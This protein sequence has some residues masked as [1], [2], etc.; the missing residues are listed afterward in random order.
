MNISEFRNKV[1]SSTNVLLVLPYLV[2]PDSI[3]TASLLYRFLV[4]KGKKVDVAA[5]KV[6]V[7]IFNNI[8]SLAGI[9]VNKILHEISP[10]RYVISVSNVSDKTS[11]DWER[12][13][14]QL[15]IKLTPDIG[16]VDFESINYSREGGIYDLVITVNVDRLS[17]LGEVYTSISK[18]FE[19]YE[20][21]SVGGNLDVEGRVIVS[22]FQGQ[23]MSTELL[24][25]YANDLDLEIDQVNA[26]II[27]HGIIGQTHGLQKVYSNNTFAIVTDIANKYQLDLSTII[28]QYFASVGI[29]N[30]RVQEKILNNLK[31]D[32]SRKTVYSYLTNR[33]LAQLGISFSNFDYNY[34][35]PFSVDGRDYYSFI[36][37]ESGLSSFVYLVSPFESE[38]YI[39]IV[40]RS[41]AIK[42]KTLAYIS[43]DAGAIDAANQVLGVISG[44]TLLQRQ[45]EE[46]K[47]FSNASSITQHID[48]VSE[49]W[50]YNDNTNQQPISA[51]TIPLNSPNSVI[52]SSPEGAY[53]MTSTNTVFDQRSILLTEHSANQGSAYPTDPSPF[54]KA[55]DSQINSVV[56]HSSNVHT[57]TQ[58]MNPS[59]PP[60]TPANT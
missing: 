24:Y 33:D 17:D 13:D 40:N 36:V 22:L 29:D 55:G 12:R 6:P 51:P 28:K 59:A 4:S 46:K 47:V 3:A 41:N 56:L 34:Y 32:E 57:Q 37:L 1:E 44:G 48:T 8:F 18:K 7:T 14:N 31:F 9:D 25:N 38:E 15:Y 43:I 50:G 39:G 19:E 21:V 45:Q 16:I 11:V 60:F 35:L 5:E 10:I 58:H 49:G 27:L 2:D 26:T 30:V 54:Q 20:I 23:W 53:T 52:P 42:N